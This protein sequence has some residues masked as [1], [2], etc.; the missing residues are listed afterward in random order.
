MFCKCRVVH[1]VAGRH[2]Q[3]AFVNKSLLRKS[4][5]VVMYRVDRGHYCSKLSV[6]V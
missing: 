6:C 4:K 3:Q 5:L 2:D 1:N